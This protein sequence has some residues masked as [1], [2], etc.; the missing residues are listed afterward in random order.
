MLFIRV[1]IICILWFGVKLM[2]SCTPP[3][4]I[5]INYNSI[6]L[7]GIDNSG[8]FMM[9][10]EGV[11]SMYANAVAFNLTLY[12][13]TLTYYTNH[14]GNAFKT[15]SFAPAMAFSVVES[16]IPV[17]K[18]EQISVTTLFDIDEDVEAGMDVSS[19]FV[20]DT[21]ND[22]ELYRNM[23]DAMATLNTTQF[24]A[25]SSIVMVLRKSVANSVAQFT[26]RVTLDNG[27]ELSLR[28]GMFTIVPQ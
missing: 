9:R 4:P 8:R 16:F 21:G 22:F 5:E 1:L 12:D 19:L 18:V 7:A 2:L 13:S 15:L 26:V 11:D 10:H 27:I 17:T 14:S 3:P 20:F 23:D 6:N 24:T 28:T 25:S